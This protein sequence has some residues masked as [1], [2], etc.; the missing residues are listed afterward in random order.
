MLFMGGLKTQAIYR[1]RVFL[2]NKQLIVITNSKGLAFPPD[3]HNSPSSLPL[4]LD[5]HEEPSLTHVQ[6]RANPHD[7]PSKSLA[8]PQKL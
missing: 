1:L 7:R 3:P 5:P 6:N 4:K 8:N 2:L